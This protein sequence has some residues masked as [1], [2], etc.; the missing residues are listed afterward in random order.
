MIAIDPDCEPRELERASG[1]PGSDRRDR[2]T[3]IFPGTRAA[4]RCCFSLLERLQA[5]SLA[6]LALSMHS[7]ERLMAHADRGDSWGVQCGHTDVE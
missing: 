7:T 6:G 3:V 1:R 5:L 2:S 4:A